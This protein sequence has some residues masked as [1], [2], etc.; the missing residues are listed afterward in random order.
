M[1]RKP[2]SKAK[3]RKTFRAGNKTMKVNG[4]NPRSFR[5]GIRL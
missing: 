3:S 1:K 2:I 4:M 5:G